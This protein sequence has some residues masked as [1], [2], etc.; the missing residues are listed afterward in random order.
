M[1]QA[2]SS[3]PNRS[4]TS[5]FRLVHGMLYHSVVRLIKE[6]VKKKS[7]VDVFGTARTSYFFD[8]T[9]DFRLKLWLVWLQFPLVIVESLHTGHNPE[10]M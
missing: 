2:Y 7:S 8:C 5:T 3:V 6:N 4:Q 1:T 10:E 9:F